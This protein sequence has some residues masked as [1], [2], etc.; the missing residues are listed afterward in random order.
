MGRKLTRKELRKVPGISRLKSYLGAY[1]FSGKRL[2]TAH[3]II[4]L[5]AKVFD[6][7]PRSDDARAMVA[8]L[9]ALTKEER[10]TRAAAAFARV[11][12]SLPITNVR[13]R[14]VDQRTK[15]AAGQ[16]I[17]VTEKMIREFYDSPPWKRLSYDIKKERGRRCECCGATPDQG[18]RIITDHIKPLR[19]YW[20]LR[21][22]PLNMQVLC[23][24]CNL[25][26]GSRDETDWRA[27]KQPDDEIDQRLVDQL[28]PPDGFLN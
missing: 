23:D 15:E 24:D 12:A 8:A 26:K 2:R 6:L 10:S 14:R 28:T 3:E 22:D 19:K 5:T 9:V 21:L 17:Q 13:R 20:H 1:G 18:V 7:H 25:G 27:P 11:G 4:V 16:I